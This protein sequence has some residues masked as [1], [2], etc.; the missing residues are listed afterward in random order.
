MYEKCEDVMDVWLD[1][2]S[3][4]HCL[5]ALRPGLIPFPADIYL[6]GSDQHRGWFHSS[7][8]VSVAGRGVAPYRQVITHGF[9]GGRVGSEDVEV[10]R[11]RHRAA[12][13]HADARRR[14]APAL[15]RGDRLQR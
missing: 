14:C 4:H 2:G 7:L 10:A 6:E 5:P 12:E 8:L 9:L 3:V 1:S 11:Q 15:G 13:G